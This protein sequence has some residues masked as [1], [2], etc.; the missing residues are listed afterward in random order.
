M[1]ERAVVEVLV[2]PVRRFSGR[3]V[4]DAELPSAADPA[5]S[6]T[7]SEDVPGVEDPVV[8]LFTVPISLEPMLQ[9]AVVAVLVV[10]VSWVSEGGLVHTCCTPPMLA[11]AVVAVLVV[12][13]TCVSQGGLEQI[14]AAAVVAVLVVPVSWVSHGGLEQTRVMVAAPSPAA[15]PASAPVVEG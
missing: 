9:L 7:E 14:L 3:M 2:V 11:E 5:V 12:P 6:E 1:L 10:P 4:P 15:S 8:L 13:V